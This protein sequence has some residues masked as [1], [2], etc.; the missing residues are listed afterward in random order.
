MNDVFEKMV[1]RKRY[2]AVVNVVQLR[3]REDGAN[4][5]PMI[6]KFRSEYDKL[7]V[8][9]MEVKLTEFKNYISVLEVDMSREER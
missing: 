8:M 6:V 3:Q 1:L 5:F 2:E 9:R 7:I 4:I